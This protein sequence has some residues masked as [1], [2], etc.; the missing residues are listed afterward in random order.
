[1]LELSNKTIKTDIIKT[2]QRALLHMLETNL[3][4]KSPQKISERR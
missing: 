2:L 4:P 3:T 1:M